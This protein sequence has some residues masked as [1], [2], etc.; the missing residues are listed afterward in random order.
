MCCN[1]PE[2]TRTASKRLTNDPLLGEGCL[3]YVHGH[4]ANPILSTA[5][6]ATALTGTTC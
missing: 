3:C 2:I 5:P 6:A 4:D 1:Y